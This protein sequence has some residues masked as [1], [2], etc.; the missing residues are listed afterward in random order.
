MRAMICTIIILC[1]IAM[2]LGINIAKHGEPRTD[3]YNAWIYLFCV[4]IDIL[5]FWGA[6]LFDN[7][8]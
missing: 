7:F 8:K 1:I 3:R 5:L 2:N 4:A 6:G